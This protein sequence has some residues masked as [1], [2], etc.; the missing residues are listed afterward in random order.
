FLPRKPPHPQQAK[1]T[2]EGMLRMWRVLRLLP[3]SE[4]RTAEHRLSL[5][6]VRLS[7]LR[8]TAHRRTTSNSVGNRRICSHSRSHSVELT[9]LIYC[10]S[11]MVRQILPR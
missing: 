2:I 9:R 3:T 1:H 10:K 11:V 7:I 8:S 5:I 4:T 6:I